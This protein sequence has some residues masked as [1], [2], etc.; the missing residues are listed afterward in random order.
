MNCEIQTTPMGNRVL[1]HT[2]QPKKFKSRIPK[3]Q[4]PVNKFTPSKSPLAESGKKRFAVS[5]D[6][7]NHERTPVENNHT[8]NSGNLS[9]QP[10]IHTGEKPYEY[11]VCKS[12]D[13]LYHTI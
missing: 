3:T 12:I 6:L 8:I 1:A 9:S 4:F 5:C 7:S 13:F 11:D 2:P 10:R